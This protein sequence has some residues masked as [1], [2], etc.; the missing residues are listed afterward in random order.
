MKVKKKQKGEDPL[1]VKRVLKLNEH[2]KN[3]EENKE[4]L[5]SIR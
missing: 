5:K 2:R 1:M 3:I 4:I